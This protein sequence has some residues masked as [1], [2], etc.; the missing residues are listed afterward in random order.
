MFRLRHERFSYKQGSGE[1]D[2]GP[3]RTRNTTSLGI[4]AFCERIEKNEEFK[5]D[6]QD[7]SEFRAAFVLLIQ[8]IRQYTKQQSTAEEETNYDS[9]EVVVLKSTTMSSKQNLTRKN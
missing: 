3:K 7:I 9:K 1:K 4:Q 2:D 6:Q 5:F 8:H